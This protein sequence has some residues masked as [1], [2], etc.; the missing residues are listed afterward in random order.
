[1]TIEPPRPPF[2]AATPCLQPRNTPSTLIAI[3]RW[4]PSRVSSSIFAGIET[5][6]Q[7]TT[8]V[9]LPKPLSAAGIASDQLSCEVTSSR[10]KRA[11]SPSSAASASPFSACRSQMT[12]R[13]PSSTKRLALAAPIPLAPPVIRAILS[14]RRI[15]FSSIRRSKNRYSGP[16]QAGLTFLR[17]RQQLPPGTMRFSVG[18]LETRH[19]N[20]WEERLCQTTPGLCAA[21]FLPAALWHL[22]L[23]GPVWCRPP[24]PRSPPR[25]PVRSRKSW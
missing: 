19:G 15:R 11:A 1:M 12:T 8:V 18:V 24:P 4:K 13:A 2:R 17:M 14:L 6:A 7:L 22:H 25:K 3:V 5:P 9:R 23:P 10:T 16:E 20:S 21:H